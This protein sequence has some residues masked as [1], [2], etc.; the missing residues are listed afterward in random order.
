VTVLVQ[1][2]LRPGLRSRPASVP[3]RRRWSTP[4]ALKVC[5]AV[6]VLTSAGFATAAAVASGRVRSGFDAIGHTEAPQVVAANELVY[7]LNDMDANLANVLLVGGNR[8]GPGIDRAS[9]TKL[10]EQDRADADRDLQTAAVR[11]GGSGAAARQVNQV[12]DALGSY[13]A[14]AAQVMYLDAGHGARP[15]GQVP[16]EESALFG[17]ATDLMQGT[18]LPAARAVSTDNGNAL[19][20]SYQSRHGLALAAAWWLGGAGAAVVVAL[21]GTQILL[22]RRTNRVLNPALAGATLLALGLTVWGVSS[23]GAA[24]EHLRVAK[25]DAFDSISALTAAKAVSTDANADESRLIVD[26]ARADEYRQDFLAASRELVDLGPGVTLATYD[27]GLKSDLDAYFGG[28]ARPPVLF[29]GYYGAEMRNITFPGERAAAEQM[30][31]AYQ[32]YEL[33]DRRLRQKIGTDLPEAVRFDTS[34]A[35]G[36]SDGAF[37]AYAAAEQRVIDINSDA[38]DAGIAAGLRGMGPWPWVPLGGAGLV[39]VLV[40]GGVRARLVEYR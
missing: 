18:V 5:T 33:D 17:Q 2:D 24:A 25:K 15:A 31:R 30:L 19:E 38:F 35:A 37:V 32:A 29:G 8:L 39:V 9:F 6:V 10:Y 3:P 23:M 28:P 16:A 36:D 22:L 40:V 27:A 26:P 1:P 13:E 14:L 20:A 21:G 11:A 12:L 4:A 7:S 34:P